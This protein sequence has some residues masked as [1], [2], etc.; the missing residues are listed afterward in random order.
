MV[1]GTWA[2]TINYVDGFSGPWNIKSENFADSSFAIRAPRPAHGAPSSPRERPLAELR[3]FFIEANPKSY[4]RLEQFARE[5]KDA[6]VE[7]RNSEFIAASRTSRVSS[8]WWAARLRLHV[9]RPTGWTGFAIN[10]IKQL[11]QHR[12]GEVLINIHDFAYQAFRGITGKAAPRGVR[13]LVRRSRLPR[14]AGRNWR[15]KT[16]RT[17]CPPVYA[18]CAGDGRFSGTSARPWSCTPRRTRPTFT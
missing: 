11:L 9:H 8:G 2:D 5:T 16:A 3:C 14:R 12:P 6:E 15:R 7:T 1:V 4:A 13:G 10:K 17:P 18:Q